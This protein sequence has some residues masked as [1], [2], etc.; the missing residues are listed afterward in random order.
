MHKN[1]LF[2]VLVVAG[3]LSGWYYLKN[4]PTAR[5]R[6]GSAELTVELAV[7]PS[8]KEKG[9]G[10]RTTLLPNHGMLFVYDHKEQYEFWMRDMRFA[11]DFI[12]IEGDIVSDITLGVLP[13]KAEEK[14]A[15]VK[16]KA[17]VDKVLEV[18]AGTVER[19]G[20]APGNTVVFVSR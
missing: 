10:G 12:W 4:P 14:P 13:P 18:T 20:I 17:T 7:T 5:V 8:E 1:L 19:L 15:I 9:L 16:P 2:I 11:L 3:A 6:I